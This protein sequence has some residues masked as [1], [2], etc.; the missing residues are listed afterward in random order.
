MTELF[1][2]CIWIGGL[3][4]TPAEWGMWK[5]A[6]WPYQLGRYLIQLTIRHGVQ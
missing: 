1:V 6:L 5:S 2:L 3:F 4:A